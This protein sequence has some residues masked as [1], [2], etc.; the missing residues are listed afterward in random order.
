MSKAE[1][2]SEQSD[3]QLKEKNLKLEV[4]LVYY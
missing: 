4:L 3:F 1:V 2:N